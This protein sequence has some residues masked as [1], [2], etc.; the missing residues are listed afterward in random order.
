M[1]D[2]MGARIERVEKGSLAE[3]LG[4]EAGDYLY[5]INGQIIWDFLDYQYLSYEEELDLQIVKANGGNWSIEIDKDESEDLG[6][7]FLSPVFDGIRKCRNKCVFCFVDQMPPGMRSTLYCKDDDY[8]LS[9]LHGNYITLTNLKDEDLEKIIQYRLTPL[10]ISVHTTNSNLRIKMMNNPT[11][12]KIK[13]QLTLL[14]KAG[15]QINVQIVLCPGLNDREFLDETISDLAKLH[16][17]LISIAVVP[18]GLTK[19]RQGLYPLETICKEK[20]IQI[21]S[22]VEEWQRKFKKELGTKLVFLSDEFYLTAGSEFPKEEEYE[23]FP[24]I[25]NGVG[26]AR[27]F[28][29]DFIKQER[30]LPKSLPKKKRV[31]IISGSSAAK[32]LHRIVDKLNK[33]K[34]LQVNLEIIKNS[35]FGTSITV[36]G[37]LT[38]ADIIASLKNKELG[39]ELLIPRILLKEGEEVLLDGMKLEDLEKALNIPVRIM[40]DDSYDFVEK[41]LEV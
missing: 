38:G 36:T 22:Q 39:N 14:T 3:E 21:I 5:K 13:E 2:Y 28:L 18:V 8:R 23:D 34:N 9:F 25:E 11:A 20:A 12:G 19:H 26:L 4:L 27:I 24:Q 40:E 32:F 6:L 30:S 10:Y 33:I 31:T 37:L 7:E 29:D 35:F 41:I 1:K 16:P 17:Q 15:I